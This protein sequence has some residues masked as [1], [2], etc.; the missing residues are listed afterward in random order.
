M[1]GE[2]LTPEE[3]GEQKGGLNIL[4]QVR[5][6]LGGQKTLSYKPKKPI[7][8]DAPSNDEITR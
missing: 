3:K 1:N 6:I 8:P 4:A 5:K 7:H 2:P